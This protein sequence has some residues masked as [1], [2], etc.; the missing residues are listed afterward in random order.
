MGAAP[1]SWHEVFGSLDAPTQQRLRERIVS[2]PARYNAF[3]T[4][5]NQERRWWEIRLHGDN[6]SSHVAL[7]LELQGPLDEGALTTA[8]DVLIEHH[9]VLRS[10]LHPLD[11]GIWQLVEPVERFGP[12][13]EWQS[14][15]G[16]VDDA[17]LERRWRDFREV[18]F[19][20]DSARW[21]RA[22]AVRLDRER[23]ALMLVVHHIAF[24][25]WSVGVLVRQLGQ[26]YLAHRGHADPLPMPKAQVGDFAEWQRKRLLSKHVNEA[27]EYW[28]TQLRD[29][30]RGGLGAS[31][32]VDDTQP[33]VARHG[34]W[35]SGLAERVEAAA[36]E[37][38]V[39]PFSWYAAC[40]LQ[41][42]SGVTGEPRPGVAT[43]AAALRGSQALV[44][45]IGDFGALTML[46]SPELQTEATIADAARGLQAQLDRHDTHASVPMAQ[47]LGALA[48]RGV[49]PQGGS[50]P[51]RT[52]VNFMRMD[53]PDRAL[54]LPGITV[55]RRRFAPSAQHSPFEVEWRIFG[56][57]QGFEL[58]HR[59]GQF[60]PT[61][62]KRWHEAVLAVLAISVDQP[63]A[64]AARLAAE[65]AARLRAPSETI[66]NVEEETEND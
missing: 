3:P 2:D 60:T 12:V 20:L 35:P 8:F 33:S 57:S 21:L 59:D 14:D 9:E 34:S 61:E 43:F 55:I 29:V 36:R 40:W 32:P 63:S 51:V 31:G 49:L 62:C 25:D 10:S 45:T 18:P 22:R 11:R 58:L 28:E 17:E 4:T 66:S 54:E 44:D 7:C 38:G 15:D 37:A 6:V 48:R 47:V 5:T 27:T 65:A 39:T 46:T 52:V 56:S 19:T 41:L 64:P 50:L 23:V 53:D 13:L 26:A 16:V 30:D 1:R 42:V 24:D